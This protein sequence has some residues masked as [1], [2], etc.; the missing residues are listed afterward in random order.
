MVWCRYTIVHTPIMIISCFWPQIKLHCA[1]CFAPYFSDIL[2]GST[3]CLS[4]NYH[5][6]LP[7]LDLGSS[8]NSPPHHGLITICA[9]VNK[10]KRQMMSLQHYENSFDFM[11][12]WKILRI[13]QRSAFHNLKTTDLIVFGVLHQC[14][15]GLYP[16]QDYK[17]DFPLIFYI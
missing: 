16:C 17:N 4:L 7:C 14:E 15:E 8:P 13:L 10:V 5:C 2:N 6:L 3:T 9:T 1:F 12:P 11:D